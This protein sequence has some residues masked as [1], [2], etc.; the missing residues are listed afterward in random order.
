MGKGAAR[1]MYRRLAMVI[2]A[3][4]V[5]AYLGL[6]AAFNEV[7][8]SWAQFEAEKTALDALLTHRA[9]HQ[10]VV[11]VQRP[12]IYR[13]K[14]EGH[15]YDDY[16]SPKVMSFTYIARSVK[17]HLN[18]ERQRLGISEIYFKLASDNPRNPINKADAWESALLARMNTESIAEHTEIL[19]VDGQ[20]FLTLA[21]PVARNDQG[22]MA[23]HGDPKNAPAELVRAYGDTAGFWE[24]PGKIRAIIS[25]RVPM[26]QVQ[27]H[28][29]QIL[30]GLAIA[31]LAGMAAIH[32]LVIWLLRRT[33][34]F[35]AQMEIQN[36]QLQSFAEAAHQ[37]RQR[38]DLL[39]SS[40]GEG[41]FGV[42]PSGR[43]AFTNPA[44]LKMLGR[45]EDDDVIGLDAHQLTGHTRSDGTLCSAEDCGV[46]ATLADGHP[47]H[48]E[49]EFYRRADGTIFPVE[50]AVTALDR[51]EGAVVI[52][53]DI[54][55]RRANE[56]ALANAFERIRVQSEELSRINC[57]LEQFAYVASHDLRQP[58]RMISSYLSL[59]Q[60]KLGARLEDPELAEFFGFT[61][62]GARRMDRMITA[63][64]DYSRTG[65]NA[66]EP[67][68]VPLEEAVAES[69]R[70]L[71]PA[72][73]TAEAR[74]KVADKLPTVLGDPI[75]LARLFQNL[76][77][78]A[79][80]YRAPDRP[81]AIDIAV[82][83]APGEW[84]V[85]VCDNGIGIPA[86]DHDRAFQIFQRLAAN[87]Q[88]EG[89]GI[90]LAICKKIAENHGG[91]IWLDSTEGQGTCF[92][93]AFPRP[94]GT[95]E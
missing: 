27:D 15:L 61:I 25:I 9:V 93:I 10:H 67:V 39:L 86:R 84:V 82:R 21:V 81:P 91:R 40:A 78:N 68:L 20:R 7:V 33:F 77:G 85:S 89:A 8:L 11:T 38:A 5:V 92:H 46:L 64:L 94:A 12:E 58:L 14:T 76:I 50:L 31:M 35:Q 6:L 36:E 71:E 28:A 65:R 59:I 79:V 16:F 26:A 13:L 2:T 73:L 19:D 18:A 75:D 88:V 24:Q 3:V 72:I 30:V 17:D 23:C 83:E 43:V 34:R 55:E 74:V 45:H 37:A 62:D 49:T 70:A 63:L 22:C 87:P 4:F 51:S 56:R 41:I 1:S 53:H 54:S 42:S 57:E 44:A 29:R 47:R 80:K 95:A 90:G 69:L 66:A 60:K 48:M 32:A 52:F